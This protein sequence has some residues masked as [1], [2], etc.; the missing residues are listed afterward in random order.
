MHTAPVARRGRPTGGPVVAADGEQPVLARRVLF[1][2][3]FRSDGKVAVGVQQLAGLRVAMRVVAEI[4]LAQAG[5]DALGR[6]VGER[7]VQPGAS[8]G[9]GGI[10]LW[11]AG[12]VERP[13]PRDQAPAQ[14]GA[15]LLQGHRIQHPGRHIGAMRRQLIGRR[16]HFTRLGSQRPAPGRE[17]KYGADE[18][19]GDAG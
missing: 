14:P 18:A 17:Q 4:D 16:W 2:Q 8:V 1:A 6:R 13:R 10:A 9:E 19:E 15:A 11:R 5:V 7:P 12:D 3:D